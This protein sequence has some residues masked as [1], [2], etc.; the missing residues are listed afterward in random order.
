MPRTT[1][2]IG[3]GLMGG[4]VGIALRRRGWVVRYIDPNVAEA[5]AQQAG[6]ADGRADTL[7]GADV[8][9]L[10]TP[11]DVAVEMLRGEGEIA[12]VTTSLCSVMQPLRAVARGA[13]VAGHPMAGWHEG[14]LV[15]AHH[16]RLEN[17]QW[18]LDAEDPLVDELVRDCGANPVRVDAAEHDAAV[19]LTSHLPQV[20]STA[21]FAYLEGRDVERFAGEGLRSFRLAASDRSMWE[22][23]LA[24]N[25]ENLRP[26]ADAIAELVRAIIEGRDADAFARAGRLWQSLQRSARS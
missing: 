22:P 8:V 11:I 23:V 24:A 17:A 5:D 20:L 4:A 19:A 6:A 2:I 10:A 25:R 12:A 26:H 15:N 9:V 16:V 14:G 21:L 3:L 7:Q 1:T 18:F 13:F